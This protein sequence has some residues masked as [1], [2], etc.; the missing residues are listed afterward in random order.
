MSWGNKS[1]DANLIFPLSKVSLMG[2]HL[3]APGQ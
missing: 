2:L 3:P 1:Y